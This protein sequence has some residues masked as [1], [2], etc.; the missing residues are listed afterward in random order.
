MG[1]Q[2][3]SDGLVTVNLFLERDVKTFLV[4]HVSQLLDFDLC[5]GDEKKSSR[6]YKPPK[7]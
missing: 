3:F 2:T 5:R 4:W 7:N 6:W 1:N